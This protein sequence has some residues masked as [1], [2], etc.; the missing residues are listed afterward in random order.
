[1]HVHLHKQTEMQTYV[2][3]NIASR[4]WGGNNVLFVSNLR[5]VC[6]RF[7]DKSIPKNLFI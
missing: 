2:T 7:E 4:M 5:P 1:M 3:D 6:E